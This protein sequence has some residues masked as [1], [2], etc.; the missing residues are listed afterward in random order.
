MKTSFHSLCAS[1]C[2]WS[3]REIPSSKQEKPVLFGEVGTLRLQ[4]KYDLLNPVR[5]LWIITSQTIIVPRERRARKC[6]WF[7]IRKAL[8]EQSLLKSK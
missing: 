6:D 7:E 4:Y 8:I 2:Y 1:D 3:L 5:M